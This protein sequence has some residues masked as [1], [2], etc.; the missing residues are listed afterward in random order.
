M[1]IIFTLTNQKDATNSGLQE[2]K[3]KMMNSI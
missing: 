2:L 3:N 1:R